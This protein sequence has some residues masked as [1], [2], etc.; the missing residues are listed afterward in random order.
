MEDAQNIVCPRCTHLCSEDAHFC[1]ECRAPISSYAATGPFESIFAEGAAY[2]SAINSPT[3]PIVVVGVWL[4]FL[5]FVCFGA[6]AAIL[7]V[8]G[9]SM[10]EI[11]DDDLYIVNWGL[12]LGP[13][14][15]Y[16]IFRTTRTYLNTRQKQKSE[17][18]AAGN[19][20]DAQ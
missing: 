7:L 15:A 9:F 6:L 2:S 17:H 11:H 14:G 4:I 10:G 13:I 19:P 1:P 5:P 18:D 12:L 8:N 20:L 3:K 16:A